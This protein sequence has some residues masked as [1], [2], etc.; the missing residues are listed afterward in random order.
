MKRRKKVSN[1]PSAREMRRAVAFAR[2]AAKAHHQGDSRG[3]C[4]Y[5]DKFV[6]H[7]NRAERMK[8]LGR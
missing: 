6:K 7:R 4:F 3:Y 1:K 2:L 8:E 5:T